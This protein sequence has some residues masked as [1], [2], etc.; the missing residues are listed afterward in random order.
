MFGFGQNRFLGIDIGTSSIKIAEIKIGNNKPILSN[1]AWMKISGASGDAQ[2]EFSDVVLSKYVRRMLGAAKFKS[3]KAYV[4][5]PAFGGLITL[6]EF[7]Q[8]S[9]EDLDQAIKFEAHKYI[10]TSMDDIALSWDILNIKNA[11]LV[12]KREEIESKMDVSANANSKLQVLL[13]AAPKSKVEKYEK[14]IAET[15]LSLNSIEIESFSVLRSLVGNDAGN[16]V[17]IDIGSRVCNIV[18]VEKGV[19]KVNRNIDAGGREITKVISRSMDID[20]E[21]AEKFKISNK[22]LLSKET[23][24]KFTTL[25][26]IIDE[27]KRVLNTYYK[28]E[29]EKRVDGI[30]LTGGTAGLSG[31]DKYFGEALNIKTIIGNPLGRIGYD[32][33]LDSKLRE[34]GPRLSVCVGLALRGAEDYFKH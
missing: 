5:M 31:I 33:K 16:F 13:V 4:S 6:I 18:L 1:Y 7:P 32:A 2:T 25:D 34:I 9:K 11:P 30:I 12:A 20:E 8:M 28:N 3:K 19:I 15:G 22:D 24:M 27:T 21:R 23:N 14:I 10:P 26:L 17:I 29:G